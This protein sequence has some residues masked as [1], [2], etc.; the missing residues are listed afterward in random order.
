MGNIS[1]IKKNIL[2]FIEYKNITKYQF[3]K[4]TGISRGVLDK[5]TGLSEDSI[6]KV[7]ACYNEINPTWLV[8]GKGSMLLNNYDNHINEN[9]VVSESDEFY[10]NKCQ[11]KQKHIDDLELMV[12]N[13]TDH[14]ND[15]RKD[16]EVYR[17]LLE[18]KI[19][20]N[21]QAG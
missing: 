11:E 13:L 5:N 12:K 1:L 4:E 8:T 20:I 10:Y 7:I 9:E 14:I 21:K 17:Q 3:Y 2:Q 19:S 6:T 18:N 16:K 15:I